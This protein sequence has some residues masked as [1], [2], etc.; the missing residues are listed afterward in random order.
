M[1]SPRGTGDPATGQRSRDAT[2]PLAFR[3]LRRLPSLHHHLVEVFEG[4]VETLAGN[5]ASGS[6]GPRSAAQFLHAQLGLQLLRGPGARQVLLVGDDEQRRSGRFRSSRDSR[7]FR[8]RLVQSVGVAGVDD[9]HD[10][11]CASR[12]RTPQG[13]HLVLSAYV[14]DVETHSLGL[15]CRAANLLAVETNGGHR[16][17]VLRVCG[18]WG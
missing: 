7:K 15:T 14:P 4:D 8:P 17:Y 16:V 12:V 2:S 5:G 3:V 13:A 10:T 1:A 6:N 18:V 9:E 11:V